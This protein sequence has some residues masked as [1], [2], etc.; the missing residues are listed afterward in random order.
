MLKCFKQVSFGRASLGGCALAIL[1][2]SSGAMAQSGFS[3]RYPEHTGSTTPHQ[4]QHTLI[5]P[6]ACVRW[7]SL[8]LNP[9]DP[10]QY[11]ITDGRC[12]TR[13]N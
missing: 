2:S 9:C 13:V 5:D 10:A 4:V 3:P 7:C 1:L 8:D 11:K 12:T 6:A